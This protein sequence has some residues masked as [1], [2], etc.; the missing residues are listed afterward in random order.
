M[1]IALKKHNVWPDSSVEHRSSITSGVCETW[2]HKGWLLSSYPANTSSAF[3]FIP[4][5]LFSWRFFIHPGGGV[6]HHS[7]SNFYANRSHLFTATLSQLHVSIL[8]WFKVL[9][10]LILY[11]FQ[12][13]VC[14]LPLI[15]TFSSHKYYLRTLSVSQCASHWS[16]KP[17]EDGNEG[18]KAID[19]TRFHGCSV[20]QIREHATDLLWFAA[21][22]LIFLSPE[23]TG[24]EEGQ[25]RKRSKP[26]AFPTAEDI[27]SKFQHLSHFDQHQVT[28]QVGI[29]TSLS[30]WLAPGF[31]NANT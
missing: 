16:F 3:V 15:M 10:V 11:L 28:S 20:W 19:L 25:K 31:I 7:N 29:Y 24:G 30:V 22:T 12:S 2:F 18:Q 21:P 26:E 9:K 17:I 8:K 5:P 4:L 13:V 14:H 27:F 6:L 23:N 1:S